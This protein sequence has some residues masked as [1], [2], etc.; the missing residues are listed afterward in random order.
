MCVAHAPP[1]L[2]RVRS[3]QIQALASV[4]AVEAA[5]PH[6]SDEDEDDSES[7]SESGS[8]SDSDS[9]EDARLVTR[10]R[11]KSTFGRVAPRKARNAR[12][13]ATLQTANLGFVGYRLIALPL[14]TLIP[15]TTQHD[16]RRI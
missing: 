10:M 13:T 8:D 9:A 14:T 12:E 11:F 7:D 16:C 4:A 3:R 1:F 5:A 6:V 2:V 15:T